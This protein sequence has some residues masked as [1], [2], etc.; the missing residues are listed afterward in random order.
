MHLTYNL[1][2]P[3]LNGPPILPIGLKVLDLELI[4]APGALLKPIP[5]PGETLGIL[6]A[7]GLAIICGL[8]KIKRL[9]VGTGTSTGSGQLEYVCGS[10]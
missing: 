2:L 4:L 7:L 5:K 3:L 8:G 9:L 1:H 6:I 10:K